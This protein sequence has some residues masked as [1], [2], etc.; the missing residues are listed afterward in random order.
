VREYQGHS[1]FAGKNFFG[2]GAIGP[3]LLHRP[4][5]DDWLHA[6]LTTV[7]NG[8]VRQTGRLDDA[9]FQPPELIAYLSS[10]TPLYPGDVIALGT[11][12]GV[13]MAE[14]PPCW[15]QP[16][17]QVT[18]EVDKQVVLTVTVAQPSNSGG[19]LFSG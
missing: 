9:I 12:S 19:G 10:I 3:K 15:L 2:S 6:E 5:S 14:D 7:I 17:D 16:G 1:L 11:P 8:N 18:V 13:G 4:W